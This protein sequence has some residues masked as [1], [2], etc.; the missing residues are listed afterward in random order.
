MASGEERASGAP[1][2]YAWLRR[3]VRVQHAGVAPGGRVP[4]EWRGTLTDVT[5]LGA[6]VE[7]EGTEHFVPWANIVRLT[8]LESGGER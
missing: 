3:R 1:A 8:L 4:V 2:P 7:T 6:T 5:N